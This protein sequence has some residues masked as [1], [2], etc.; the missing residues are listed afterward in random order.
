MKRVLIG[1]VS[2]LLLCE[3]YFWLFGSS[4]RALVFGNVLFFTAFNLLEA[5]LPSLVS[6]AAPAGGKEPLW[7]SVQPA[8]FWGRLRG[9]VGW[10]AALSRV[11]LSVSLIWAAPFWYLLGFAA[12]M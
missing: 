11:A 8:S 12:T 4:L 3:L 10:L 1:A 9:H 2:V 5:T 6:K 7:A